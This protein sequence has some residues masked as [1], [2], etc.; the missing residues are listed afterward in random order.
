MTYLVGNL[1]VALITKRRKTSE[2]LRKCFWSCI[3]KSSYATS[4]LVRKLERKHSAQRESN[5]SFFIAGFFQDLFDAFQ[6]FKNLFNQRFGIAQ[7]CI[8]NNWRIRSVLRNTCNSFFRIQFC[9]DMCHS[10]KRIYTL[11]QHGWVQCHCW[12]TKLIAQDL[13]PTSWRCSNIKSRTVI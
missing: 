4:R 5:S 13:C 10:V 9:A 12:N 1:D 8:T 2:I 6:C 3:N 11:S 7:T